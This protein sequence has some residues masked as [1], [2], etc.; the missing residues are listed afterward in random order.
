M[1]RAERASLITPSNSAGSWSISTSR[2]AVLVCWI[3]VITTSC[4]E[5]LAGRVSTPL[6]SAPQTQRNCWRWRSPRGYAAA[7]MLGVRVVGGLELTFRGEPLQA[8]PGRPARSLL[9]WLATHPGTHA[10][11]AVAAALWPD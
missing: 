8:P 9:G 11:G 10:R 7:D 3:A 4:G 5:L 6:A 1:S 2:G